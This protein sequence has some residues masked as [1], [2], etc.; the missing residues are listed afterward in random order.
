MIEEPEHPGADGRKGRHAQHQIDGPVV[1]AAH[2]LVRSDLVNDAARFQ[3]IDPDL[4]L[5]A[6]L[7]LD[8]PGLV[9]QRRLHVNLD[10]VG[11]GGGAG[12]AARDLSLNPVHPE[13]AHGRA[14]EVPGHQ[15]PVAEAEPQ[16]DRSDTPFLQ[17]VGKRRGGVRAHR[18]EQLDERRRRHH[19]G[20]GADVPQPRRSQLEQGITTTRIAEVDAGDGEVERNL[21]VRFEVKVRQVERLA[22]NAVPVLLVTGEPLRLDRDALVAQQALVPLEGLPA[23]RVLG[24]I[25][26][27]LVRD[28][29]ERQGL[30][31]VEQH[32]HQ[33]GDALQPIELRGGLHR[34]EPTAGATT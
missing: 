27:H 17:P 33:I 19:G 16:P 5:D 2:H 20:N 32:E 25:A 31:G 24:G 6:V 22:V 29:V 34:P 21:L 14:V 11:H 18:L 4:H 12:L 8:L 30:V 28:G 3:R 9:G 1:E 23:G 26:G 10:V 13:C 7:A 15:V